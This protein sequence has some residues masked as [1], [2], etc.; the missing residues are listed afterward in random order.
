MTEQLLLKL[1]LQQISQKDQ[2]NLIQLPAMFKA[3]QRTNNNTNNNN[4]NNINLIKDDYSSSSTIY[5][6][7][8]VSETASLMMSP[9]DS[10]YSSKF[11]SIKNKLTHKSKNNF[12]FE[13]DDDNNNY[14]E[15]NNNM[16][17]FRRCYQSNKQHQQQT[18]YANQQQLLL[19]KPQIR[20]KKYTN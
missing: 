4:N 7:N 6:K 17:T 5:N 8:I 1:L 19:K 11:N 14:E 2:Q 16:Q 20:S 12:E 10:S 18:H 9:V 15:N 3:P 13:V